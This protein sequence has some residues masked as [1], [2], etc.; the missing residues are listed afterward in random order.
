MFFISLV[1][2]YLFSPFRNCN[3][4][5]PCLFC[6][7]FSSL[8]PCSCFFCLNFLIRK[9]KRICKKNFFYIFG[10]NN[11]SIHFSQFNYLLLCEF[12]MN[13]E[14]S[15]KNRSYIS[16]INYNKGPHFCP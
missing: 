16:I 14:S 1:K 9:K 12:L 5:R 11:C 6:C 13:A 7:S 4:N 10:Q 3:N 15:L 2:S 8:V